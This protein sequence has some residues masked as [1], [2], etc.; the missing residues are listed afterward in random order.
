MGEQYRRVRLMGAARIENRGGEEVET[1]VMNLDALQPAAVSSGIEL[2]LSLL[3]YETLRTQDI[4][5]CH[6]ALMDKMFEDGPQEP[7]ILYDTPFGSDIPTE[8]MPLV[9]RTCELV[10]ERSE[11]GK[12]LYVVIGQGPDDASAYVML[13]FL[14]YSYYEG[15]ADKADVLT[16]GKE[17][18]L[19]SFGDWQASPAPFGQ[20]IAEA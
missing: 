2:Y 13:M 5:E 19:H 1:K 17:G 11:D 20:K 16:D 14:L 4:I 18:D 8:H 6:K 9:K 7:P 10:I 12:P 3:S 15:E